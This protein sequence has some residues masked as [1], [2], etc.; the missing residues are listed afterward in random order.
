MDGGNT[1]GTIDLGTVF[2]L[3]MIL[4]A[5]PSDKR[6]ILGMLVHGF[7]MFSLSIFVST[8]SSA[9]VNPSTR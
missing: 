6:P 8:V 7:I 5:V 3:A 4:G 2:R 9:D 1:A